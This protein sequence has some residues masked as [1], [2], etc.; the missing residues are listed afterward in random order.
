MRS[1]LDFDSVIRVAVE[2]A[3]TA[4]GAA[5][6][7]VR[8]GSGAKEMRIAAEWAADGVELVQA[9]DA[10][11]LPASNL[12]VETGKTVAWADVAEELEGE[13]REALLALGTRSVLATPI[14][15]FDRTIG[16]LAVHRQAPGPGATPRSPSP[17]PSPAS[18]ASAST[19][20]GCSARTRSAC[21]SSP[22]SSRP[23]RW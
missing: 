7:L 21:G 8:L 17:S 6:C 19:P 12:A 23:H 9:E 3:G 1:E 16:V 20:R 15:A 2:E 4:L 10:G 22:R 18:S 5:R 11:M 13:A 14:A